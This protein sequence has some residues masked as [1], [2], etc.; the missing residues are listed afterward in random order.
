MTFPLYF[1]ILLQKSP[2]RRMIRAN[3]LLQLVQKYSLITQQT[4][5]ATSFP[6]VW[7]NGIEQDHQE[8]DY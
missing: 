7:D 6:E 5:P 3:I 4:K 1:K 8:I 2:D